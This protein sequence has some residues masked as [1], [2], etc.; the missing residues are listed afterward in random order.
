MALN[1]NDPD[2]KIYQNINGIL[3]PRPIGEAVG[4]VIGET[5]ADRVTDM[6]Q[7]SGLQARKVHVD[8]SACPSCGKTEARQD[9]DQFGGGVTSICRFCA[10]PWP[11]GA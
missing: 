5:I 4:D 2:V 9:H 10:K 11:K 6:F 8:D 1:A 7:G 3:R